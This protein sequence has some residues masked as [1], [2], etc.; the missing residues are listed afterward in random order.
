MNIDRIEISLPAELARSARSI[1]RSYARQLA[2]VIE[3]GASIAELHVPP[4]RLTPNLAPTAIGTRLA[5][6]TNTQIQQ[7]RD[8][9]THG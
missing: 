1:A 3:P 2:R 8:E 6:A 9:R 5:D 7:S 4:V